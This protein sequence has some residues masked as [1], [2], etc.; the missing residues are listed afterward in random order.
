[1]KNRYQIQIGNKGSSLLAVNNN[2]INISIEM[3]CQKHIFVYKQK[4]R[5]SGMQKFKASCGSDLSKPHF[6]ILTANQI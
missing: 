1:M 5:A 6:L 2:I 4:Y 3:F